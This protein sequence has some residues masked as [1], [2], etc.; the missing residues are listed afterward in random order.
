MDPG[1]PDLGTGA[2]SLIART[3]NTPV[4]TAAL[5]GPYVRLRFTQLP[6]V[7]EAIGNA[8]PP[9]VSVGEH[10]RSVFLNPAAL[11]AITL[12][13]PDAARGPV[14]RLCVSAVKDGLGLGEQV[15]ADDASAALIG[16]AD[17]VYAPTAELV[18]SLKLAH[19]EG[20]A[21]LTVAGDRNQ[22]ETHLVRVPQGLQA[23]TVT[24]QSEATLECVVAAEGITV[25][26]RIPAA[27]Y[28]VRA[29]S[30]PTSD[31][32][33]IPMSLA[34]PPMMEP[35]TPDSS[36][37]GSTPQEPA[38]D[39]PRVRTGDPARPVATDDGSGEPG[40]AGDSRPQSEPG[41]H[42]DDGRVGAVDVE[43]ARAELFG[44]D[45]DPVRPDSSGEEDAPTEPPHASV[46]SVTQ[47]AELE[48]HAASYRRSPEVRWFVGVMGGFAVTIGSPGTD[49][50]RVEVTREEDKHLLALLARTLA[51]NESFRREAVASAIWPEVHPALAL[52]LLADAVRRVSEALRL[53]ADDP[54]LEPIR[55]DDNGKIRLDPESAG[56][57]LQDFFGRAQRVSDEIRSNGFQ[58]AL[59]DA[60][61]AYQYLKRPPLDG[62]TG[63]WVADVRVPILA[64]I[65]VFLRLVW[66]EASRTRD[67]VELEICAVLAEQVGLEPGWESASGA[68][69]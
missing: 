52:D 53:A 57:D 20:Y 54:E 8:I 28:E 62:E 9:L 50:Q 31:S 38:T 63:T 33:P 37:G 58:G 49:G 13:G 7:V 27:G 21:L 59:G 10:P 56:S 16:V 67:T 64:D 51:E 15:W 47:E 36:D 29:L 34:P 55:V 1:S 61:L 65:A 22:S 32:A 5:D 12:T 2:A 45:L 43:E 68:G 4:R 26:L 6:D 46:P 66:V 25:E 24:G 40:A 42:A 30:V 35:P 41:G 69:S 44:A 60:S 48:P 19:V 3:L 17:G 18:A 23:T 11:P 14:A 39:E